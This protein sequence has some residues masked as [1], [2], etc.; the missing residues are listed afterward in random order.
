M[1]CEAAPAR[2]VWMD[3]YVKAGGE[4]VEIC[5]ERVAPP[6]ADPT[7][8]QIVDR[9]F[10]SR[11]PELGG[12]ELSLGAEDKSLRTEWMDLYEEF[13]GRTAKICEPERC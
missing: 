10:C 8:A 12:R 1:G 3:Q 11:H 7:I 9:V 4:V 5:G 13:G 6:V 2:K